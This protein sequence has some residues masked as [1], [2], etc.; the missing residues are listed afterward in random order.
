MLVAFHLVFIVVLLD[1]VS[2]LLSPLFSFLHHF[3]LAVIKMPF[4]DDAAVVVM[5]GLAG[6]ACLIFFV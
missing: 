1:I 4:V 6:V 2:T 3:A 5:C